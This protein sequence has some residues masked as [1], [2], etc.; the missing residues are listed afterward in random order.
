MLKAG[1]E[2]YHKKYMEE[3]M[4]VSLKEVFEDAEGKGYAVG[5]FNA[6]NLESVIAIIRAAEETGK[7]VILNYAEVH[8]PLIAIDEMGPIMLQYAKAA[9]IPV[10]VHLDH[11]SSLESCMKAIRLGFT[12]V[13]LDA[14]SADYEVNVKDTA[15]ITKLAHSIGVTVEAE[16]GHVFSSDIGVGEAPVESE[17]VDSFENVE[18]VY[19]DPDMAKDFVERTGVDALAIAFGTAHGVY[20]KKPVLDLDMLC[21]EVR[22]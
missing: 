22:D 12:S 17:T 11:G 6:T 2:T 16:L 9:S 15:L 8:A 4:L 14:S 1:N 3:K 7:P 19:T 5:A 21:M 10:C 13:M 20:T 18:D